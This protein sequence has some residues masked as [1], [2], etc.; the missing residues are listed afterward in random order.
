MINILWKVRI[1]FI[2]RFSFLG[3][4]SCDNV[5]QT[6]PKYE[7]FQNVGTRYITNKQKL[8]Q[9]FFLKI[10]YLNSR[11]V[12]LK[13]PTEIWIWNFIRW[14]S[15][16]FVNVQFWFNISLIYTTLL[17]KWVSGFYLI[18][19]IWKFKSLYE[20][21]IE[22]HGYLNDLSLMWIFSK[23]YLINDCFQIKIV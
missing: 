20:P 15:I 18:F 19:C 23:K 1:E 6:S 12:K 21:L 2:K 17:F 5:T 8:C 16:S 11:G 10:N 22:D 13:I 4:N 9:E 14:C 3:S 7:T